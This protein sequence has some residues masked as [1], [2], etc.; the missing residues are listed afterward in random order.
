MS[1][2]IVSITSAKYLFSGG[3]F[4]ISAS[5]S[6]K[7][8]LSAGAPLPPLP[9]AASPPPRSSSRLGLFS[10]TSSAL[11]W[12]RQARKSTS[13][14]E[15][16]AVALSLAAAAVTCSP[17]LKSDMSSRQWRG[18]ISWLSSSCN[19]KCALLAISKISSKTKQSKRMSRTCAADIV[20]ALSACL[21]VR[22]IHVLFSFAEF[23]HLAV[24][25]L[26]HKA[27]CVCLTQDCGIHIELPPSLVP[28]LAKLSILEHDVFALLR[29]PRFILQFLLLLALTV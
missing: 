4:G 27:K 18:S 17:C 3:S 25:L 1:E 2:I 5:P 28:R 8:T 19:S 9:P 15:E 10:A 29:A 13:S 22:N 16:R 24:T 23:E 20:S 26:Y 11:H 6:S 12:P 21:L 14:E 7:A